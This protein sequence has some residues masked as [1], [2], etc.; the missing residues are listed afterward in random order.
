[1]DTSSVELFCRD[2][3]VTISSPD[4]SWALPD[5]NRCD[6]CGFVTDGS[7]ESRAVFVCQDET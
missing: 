2:G 4:T 6:G 7:G 1:M 5:T 3:R